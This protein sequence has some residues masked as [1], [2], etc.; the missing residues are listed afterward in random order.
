MI[1][2]IVLTISDSRFKVFR[3]DLFTP[4]CNGLWFP[5]YLK[6]NKSGRTECIQNASR[7]DGL[8]G[9]YKPRL[10]L[11]KRGVSITLR[12]EFSAPKLMFGNNFDELKDLD[13]ECL[14]EKLLTVLNIMGVM[15]VSDA[16]RTAS[17]SAIHYSKNFA[18]QDGT[19][20]S[21][22]LTRLG[23]VE[24][25][26]RLDLNSTD[27]RNGGHTLR[28]HATAYSFVI[29]DKV[30]DLRAS[31]GRAYE[32]LDR[33]FN[34]QMS[35]FQETR[36]RGPPL[37]IIRIELRLKNRRKLKKVM[38]DLCGVIDLSFQSLF[39]TD[40]AQSVLKNH[41]QKVMNGARYLILEDLTDLELVD[42][43]AKSYPKWQPQKVMTL[44]LL[45]KILNEEGERGL[46]RAFTSHYNPRTLSR[47]LNDL[48]SLDLDVCKVKLKPLLGITQQLEDFKPLK[49]ADFNLL[50]N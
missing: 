19:T 46:H 20:A 2:T 31:K 42:D 4:N 7:E 23:K 30:A 11:I 45:Y 17:V 1:D 3:P 49:Q 24:Y 15:L 44:V 18:F 32:K 50:S 27:H 43:I 5:P 10:T 36:Q 28:F 25:T 29:Y 40:V 41:W 48:K 39:S 8:K 16:L 33:S 13:F 38:K 47:W 21:S 34:P 12:I 9:I 22:I 14:I 6:Q 26:K 35:L 37:E